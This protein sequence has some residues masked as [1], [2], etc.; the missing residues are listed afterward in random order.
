MTRKYPRPVVLNIDFFTAAMPSPSAGVYN[1]NAAGNRDVRQF[2]PHRLHL[3][4]LQHLTRIPAQ[5]RHRR[6]LTY[7]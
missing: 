2:R 1:E 3:D 5:N 7:Q 4:G 6:N